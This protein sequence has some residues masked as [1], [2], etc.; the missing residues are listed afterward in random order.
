MD[1]KGE[2]G[3]AR[4]FWYDEDILKKEEQ[5]FLTYLKNVGLI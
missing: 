5:E 3:I 1:F 2:K 4:E